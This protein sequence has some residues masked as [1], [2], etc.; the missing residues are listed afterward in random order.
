MLTFLTSMVADAIGST[1]AD[2]DAECGDGVHFRDILGVQREMISAL[3]EKGY[4]ATDVR[5]YKRNWYALVTGQ[6][7][8]KVNSLLRGERVSATDL[9]TMVF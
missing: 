5:V 1:N 3:Q 6:G 9:E 4:V 8:L 2:A 7:W